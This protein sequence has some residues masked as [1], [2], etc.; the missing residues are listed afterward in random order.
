[1]VK[2]QPWLWE[3]REKKKETTGFTHTG[4]EARLIR[5]Y[6]L[7]K[8]THKKSWVRN[9]PRCLVEANIKPLWK[10]TL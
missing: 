2:T 4:L 1:M 8:L 3:S 6:V 10:N 5:I 9:A 7:K